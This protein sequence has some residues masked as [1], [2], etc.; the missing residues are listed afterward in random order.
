MITK[1][2]ANTRGQTKTN[3]L[4][5]FHSFSFNYFYDPN[6]IQFGPLRVLNDDRVAAG[7]GFPEHPHNDAEVITYVLKGELAH[8]DSSGGVGVIGESQVQRMTTGTGVTHSEF[9]YSEK[10]EV[11]LIQVW[12]LPN[13]RNLEPSYEQIN[14]T[15]DDRKNKLLTIA[16]GDKIDGGVFFNQD[17]K[18]YVTNLEKNNSCSI[19]I[20]EKKKLYC[21]LIEGSVK[22]ADENYFTGD[23]AIVLNENNIKIISNSDS[24]LILF[25]VA[26]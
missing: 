8:K 6:W 11:H 7:S 25:E 26:D 16:S 1:R 3:W 2:L 14:F 19:S 4:Q 21:Y 15:K 9:N 10:N 22:I 20:P 17:A 12:F 23:A 5:S 13:K 24:E 18:I